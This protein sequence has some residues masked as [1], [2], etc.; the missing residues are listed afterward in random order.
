[1]LCPLW[2]ASSASSLYQH[3]L[4]LNRSLVLLKFEKHSVCQDITSLLISEVARL[5]GVDNYA[6]V[7]LLQLFLH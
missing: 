1:M 6:V 5:L 4:V 3:I 7:K 2:E